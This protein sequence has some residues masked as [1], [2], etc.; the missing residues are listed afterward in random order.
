MDKI[1][2]YETTA[3]AIFLLTIVLLT[4]VLLTIVYFTCSAACKGVMMTYEREKK[5]A[6]PP[7]EGSQTS[8]YWQCQ[9]AQMPSRGRLT[10]IR[11]SLIDVLISVLKRY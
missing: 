2:K 11:K 8:Y 7:S 4:I 9:S 5:A 6:T 1:A 3:L 10:R